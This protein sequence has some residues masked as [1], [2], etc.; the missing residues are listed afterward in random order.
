MRSVVKA[1]AVGA[2][3]FGMSS[4]VSAA[5]SVK[6]SNKEPVSSLRSKGVKTD[7]KKTTAMVPKSTPSRNAKVT[8]TKTIKKQKVAQ[9]KAENRKKVN[10]AKRIQ[11]RKNNI[12]KSAKINDATLKNL[13]AQKRAQQQK[14]NKLA[15]DL[16]VKT[17]RV[18]VAT[19]N[20]NHKDPSKAYTGKHVISRREH[21][22]T[23]IVDPKVP[24]VMRNDASTF[25]YYGY[26]NSPADKTAKVN[27]KL[28]AKQQQEISNYALT[29]VNSYLK[30]QG[31]APVKR[32]QNMDTHM[33]TLINRREVARIGFEHT[34]WGFAEQTF[35]KSTG[36]DYNGENLGGILADTS[37]TM[38]ELKVGVLN[39]ITTMIYQDG[40]AKWG[41][42]ELFKKSA[43]KQVSAGVERNNGSYS[44][45]FGYMFVFGTAN[46][47]GNVNL[48]NK[49]VNFATTYRQSLAPRKALNNLNVAK[50][51][52]TAL[53]KQIKSRN[54]SLQKN[55]K[56][57]FSANA[58]QFNK[59][60]QQADRVMVNKLRRI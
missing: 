8:N 44:E 43:G 46:T 24:H 36:L 37:T 7:V 6:S 4:E 51:R 19:P 34:N 14:V 40:H 31:L 9:I 27:G 21:L 1:M 23:K 60:K 30:Q 33:K 50:K 52:L 25:A 58:A 11:V 35:K 13:N 2:I 3:V 47:L 41:H 53:N 56:K 28:T 17:N 26:V 12:A 55:M 54:V 15:K 16:N 59:A 18:Y 29:L 48:Q 10:N 5:D 45:W 22:P 20:T 32:S 57:K 38:L 42:R 49:P 39:S